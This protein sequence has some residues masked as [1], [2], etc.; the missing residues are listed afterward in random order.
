M[1]ILSIYI[2]GRSNYMI[3]AIKKWGNGQ[4]IRLSKDILSSIGIN[5]ID[6]KIN[7]EIIDNKIII[8]KVS[9]TITIKELFLNFNE[10]FIQEEIDWGGSIGEEIW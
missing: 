4:G 9:E 5:S 10:V 8:E 6:E 1:Y 7:L 2:V 3:V